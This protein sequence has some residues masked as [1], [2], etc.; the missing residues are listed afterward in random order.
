MDLLGGSVHT[1][2]LHPVVIHTQNDRLL[3]LWQTYAKQ[4]TYDT[5]IAKMSVIRAFEAFLGGK[6]FKDIT[7]GDVD[8]FRTHL[9]SK[10]DQDGGISQS[11][12]RHQAG[13]LQD[14]LE[15]L[16][17][18]KR[19]RHLPSTLPNLMQLSKGEV[20]KARPKKIKSTATLAEA[21]YAL[22]N[23][24]NQTLVDE[25]D[26]GLYAW[27]QA[28]RLRR[29]VLINLKI[30]NF[31][32]KTGYID[33]QGLEA[34]AK[35]GKI[36]TIAPFPGTQAFRAVAIA[37]WEKL[38][39][40]GFRMEDA[41]FPSLTDLE[42]AKLPLD[43]TADIVPSLRSKAV[44]EKLFR[45]KVSSLIGKVLSPHSTR[46]TL[47]KAMHTYAKTYEEQKA[48]S[49]NLGH[50]HLEITHKH[51]LILEEEERLNIL[52][53]LYTIDPE[54]DPARNDTDLLIAYYEHLL[55]P[56][57]PEYLRAEQL[58]DMRRAA[59]RA[60]QRAHQYTQPP[61]PPTLA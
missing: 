49:E 12:L 60:Q 7:E 25:R 3:F 38:V 51:Y 28:S 11:T 23:M 20:A 48:W 27:A 35:N 16:I 37:W 32:P 46:R 52:D 33:Q 53:V 1:D 36:Y 29:M 8:A 24:P 58:A 4:W 6:R 54:Q 55:T 56:G 45:T 39:G 2:A 26:R 50:A 22:A 41:L 9:L 40:L 31:D 61:A 30:R 57:T 21:E 43:E 15:W 44:L 19:H 18:Q 10:R 47:T 13:H 42:Q 5:S 14:F 17:L 34:F 59:W